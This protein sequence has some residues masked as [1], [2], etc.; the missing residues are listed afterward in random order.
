[1]PWIRTGENKILVLCSGS[2]PAIA[3]AYFVGPEREKDDQGR[4]IEGRKQGFVPSPEKEWSED[5]QSRPT[6]SSLRSLSR[7]ISDTHICVCVD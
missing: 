2:N 7:N 5:G 1:L 6:L 4:S 3:A